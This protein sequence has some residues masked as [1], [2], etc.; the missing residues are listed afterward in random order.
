MV[1]R[2]RGVGEDEMVQCSGPGTEEVLTEL[3]LPKK[4]KKEWKT[5]KGR[6]IIVL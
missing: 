2:L 5:S 3:W 1:P 4:K 6:F